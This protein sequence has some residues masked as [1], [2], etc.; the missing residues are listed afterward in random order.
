MTENEMFNR[1]LNLGTGWEVYHVAFNAEQKEL[2]VYIRTVRGSLHTCGHSGRRIYDHG[3]EREWRHMNFFQ[4]RAVLIGKPPRVDCDQ[5][6]TP[7][8]AELSWAR[9]RSGF[10]LYFEVLMV[11][12]A[13]AMSMNEVSRL[14]GEHDTT[15]WPILHHYVDEARKEQ[16]WEEVKRKL[17]T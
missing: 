11:L 16:T 2:Q 8:T 7:K 15:L 1:A 12:L 10:S 14:L 13:K 3:K 6:S 4:Y 5:C 9:E 17:W